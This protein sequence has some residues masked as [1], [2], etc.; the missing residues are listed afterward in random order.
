[1]ANFCLIPQAADNFIQKV[2]D[3][4]IDPAKLAD[5]TSQERH[6]VF[7]DLVGEE[8]A[9]GVNSL[10]ESKMLLKN[11]QQG[12][13]TWARKVGGLTPEVRRDLITRIQKM[14][15]VLSPAEEQSFLHDLAATK[16]GVD[17]SAKEAQNIAN[18]SRNIEDTKAAMTNG[19]DRLEYGKAKVTLGNYV[20]ELKGAAAKP[21]IGDYLKPSNYG[22]DLTD[23]AGTAKS[24]KASLDNSAIFRQ[25]WKTMFT[26]PIKWQKNMRQ[27]FVDIVKQLGDKPVMDSIH[28]DIVSRPNYDRYVKAKLAVSNIEEAY[29]STLPEKIPILGRAYKASETAYTGFLYRQRADIFDK[30][31]EIAKKSGVNIDDKTQLQS[32]GKLVNSLT[33]R[34]Y[35]GKLE[36]AAQTVNNVFFS[37]RTL[38]SNID[39]LTAHQFQKGVTKFVR[40]Q[41]AESTAK[42]IVGTASV[43]AVAHAVKPGSVDLD[44]RSADFGKIKVGD[45]RFDVSGGMSSILTLAGRIVAQSTKNSTNGTVKKLGAGYNS[46]TGWDL[47]TNFLENKLSPGASVVKDLLKGQDSQNNKPT[48]KGEASNLLTP[49]PVTNYLELK[50]NPNSAN[51]LLATLADTLGISTNTYGKSTTNWSNAPGKELQQFQQKVGDKVFKQAND[52]YN[53][54]YDKWFKD[55]QH[56]FIDLPSD[57]KQAIMDAAKQDIKDAVFKHYDFKYTQTSEE[58][59]AARLKARETERRKR[60][61]TFDY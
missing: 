29:P 7:S 30:Y 50:N 16:L 4:S 12:Y 11:Q 25:G 26:N 43:L 49:L 10:F 28:A 57:Q 20:G 37:P 34:G 56:T 42:I 55:E 5:M 9:T 53:N 54:K 35:M 61:G 47:V 58:K 45:T 33:G 48:L 38:K 31:M 2:K 24:L 52:E 40:V 22:K 44:P 41:A 3:G 21:S 17:V 15:K 27:S 1:M 51:K 14:D 6:S 46:Q 36:G 8:N 59:Q 39:T 19:G 23:L 18:M 32:I 60:Q 13:V